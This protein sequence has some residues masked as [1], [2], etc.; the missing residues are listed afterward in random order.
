MAEKTLT[1]RGVKCPI[2]RSGD[3]LA[4]IVADSILSVT[5]NGDDLSDK[6]VIGITESVIARAA[7]LYVTVDEIAEDV[8]RLS[9]N[10]EE[11]TLINPIYSRNRFSMILKGVA[12]ATKKVTIVMPKY[13]EV[14]N[15]CDVNPFTGVNIKEY[16]SQ[17][18]KDEGCE[19]E[20]LNNEDTW[21]F[22]K[23]AIYCGLH[24]YKNWSNQYNPPLGRLDGKTFITL[25]DICKDKNPDFGLLGT[26]KATEEKLKLFPTKRIAKNVCVDVKYLI[27]GVCGKDVVVMAYGDGSY[28]DLDAGIWEM[29]DPVSSP[30]YTDEELLDSTPN[31]V[32]VKALADD[33]YKDLSGEELQ[34]AIEREI[35]LKNGMSLKGNMVSQGTTPR[36]YVNLLASLMDLTSGSGDRC[37]PIVLVQNYFR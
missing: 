3:N 11:I 34:K 9:G 30:G 12:R 10:S 31:E 4:K 13:D 21:Y 25:A 1:A 6:D 14:G 29:A 15:P 33:Q 36:R 7:N 26:N 17:I 5:N 19:C 32:K 23:C 24:D 8:K 20:I 2:I 35:S 27:K 16:Y 18:C 22:H 28:K 37:T